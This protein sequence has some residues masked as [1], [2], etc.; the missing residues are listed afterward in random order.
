L[1][2]RSSFTD[3]FSRDCI[4]G[5]MLQRGPSLSSNPGY[6]DAPRA[7][8]VELICSNLMAL[9]SPP[10]S[11][12]AQDA[13]LSAA[14]AKLVVPSVRIVHAL[15]PNV[16]IFPCWHHAQ[17][18]SNCGCTRL[19]CQF[20][21]CVTLST[22]SSNLACGNRRSSSRK[23]MSQGALWG[24]NISPRSNIGETID[25]RVILSPVGVMGMASMPCR[26]FRSAMSAVPDP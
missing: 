19:R 10:G 17:N 26:C 4:D 6:I 25:N 20:R 14:V 9:I 18:A 12:S 7:R 23:S 2:L 22:W 5:C 15:L 13:D 21:Y 16:S 1:R 3:E 11:R 8:E 24:R